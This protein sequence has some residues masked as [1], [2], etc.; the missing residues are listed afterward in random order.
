[1]KIY[2]AGKNMERAQSAMSALIADGHEIA[3]D[4]VANMPGGPTKEK[5]VLEW[6]ALRSSDIISCHRALE[7]ALQFLSAS[8][9]RRGEGLVPLR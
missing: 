3:Y 6:E 9:G 5:A 8:V 4:W 1:M 2:V 7:S